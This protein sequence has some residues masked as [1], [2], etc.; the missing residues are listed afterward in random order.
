MDDKNFKYEKAR[1]LLA[2]E[3]EIP[4]DDLVLNPIFESICRAIRESCEDREG[5]INLTIKN[6]E[7]EKA[8]LSEYGQ[9]VVHRFFENQYPFDGMFE[10]YQKWYISNVLDKIDE[11]DWS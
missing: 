6:R 11:R 10:Q 5:E 1:V 4:P 9:L 7:E 2:Y 8:I 3:L